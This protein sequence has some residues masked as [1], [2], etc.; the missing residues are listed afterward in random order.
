MGSQYWANLFVVEDDFITAKSLQH[1]LEELGY[2]VVGTAASGEEALKKI[3]Y[4]RPDLV[5]MDIRLKGEMDGVFTA[6]RVQSQFDIPVVYLTAFSDDD[7][8]K[9]VLHS[10]SYGF[11]VKP[12]TAEEL[13]SVIEKA[14][15]KHQAKKE[16]KRN[17]RSAGL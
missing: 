8:V 2:R 7:T 3:S 17:N 5:L 12:Y 6:Q 13:F 9:R 16:V 10:R 4:L 15:R 11:I 1:T 14:L